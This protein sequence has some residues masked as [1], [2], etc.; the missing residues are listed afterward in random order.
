[1]LARASSEMAVAVR[2]IRPVSQVAARPIGS[3]KTVSASGARHAMQ[4]LVPPVIGRAR[5]AAR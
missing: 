2:K 3:G 1:M 4:T 5:P